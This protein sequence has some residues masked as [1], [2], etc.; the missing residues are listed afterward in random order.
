MDGGSGGADRDVLGRRGRTSAD[1]ARPGLP[2]SR[3]VYTGWRD[4]VDTV[5][6]STPDSHA[7]AL[8]LRPDCY[9][10]WAS[11]TARPDQALRASAR[12][13]LVTWFAAPRPFR[14]NRHPQKCG[15]DPIADLSDG[16]EREAN[17][18]EGV[19]P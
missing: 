18:H 13:A 19:Q 6:G 5:T 14:R 2:I 16:V 17:T 4:R 12:A 7:C 8:L 3:N 9:I 11:D 1:T 15:R 10:A